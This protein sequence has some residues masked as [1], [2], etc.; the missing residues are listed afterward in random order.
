MYFNNPHRRSA[1]NNRHNKSP[2]SIDTKHR[3][4]DFGPNPF[5]VNIEKATMSNCYYRTALWT[6]KHLQVSLM[7]INVGQ[8]IGL[9]IH[10][11]TDQFIRVEEGYGLV[12]IGDSKERMEFQSP[13]Y[14]NC[15]I[16]IPAGK[17]HNIINLGE[18]PLKLYSIYAP[19]HHPHGTIHE[20]RKIADFKEN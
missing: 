5:V 9:E 14:D 11:Y 19:P 17:W 7:S 16:I 2:N 1:P 8:D 6:G 15:A 12:V 18:K 13:I 20:T 4:T 10:P 3:K